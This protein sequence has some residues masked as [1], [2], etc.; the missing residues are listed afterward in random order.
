MI[1]EETYFLS[2]RGAKGQI[3]YECEI[4][5]NQVYQQTYE[6]VKSDPE[7]LKK[8]DSDSMTEMEFEATAQKKAQKARKK[9][10][11]TST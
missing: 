11:P 1:N 4:I 8:V 7:L 3:D 2:L 9:A 10:L 6:A 5:K